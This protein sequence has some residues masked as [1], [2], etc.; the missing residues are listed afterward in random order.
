M[1]AVEIILAD[2]HE[3]PAAPACN[4]DEWEQ[5]LV[6]NDCSLDVFAN[7]WNLDRFAL[8]AMCGAAIARDG[9][10][11]EMIVNTV[12][13]FAATREDAPMLF[14]LWTV[15]EQWDSCSHFINDT[16]RASVEA[17]QACLSIHGES[18]EVVEQVSLIKA[19]ESARAWH[20]FSVWVLSQTAA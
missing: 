11:N 9:L 12:S 2:L 7:K 14:W 13:G 18:Q 16:L 1:A 4:W 3:N 10:M 8:K 17:V 20:K 19:T 6:D 5:F 15:M